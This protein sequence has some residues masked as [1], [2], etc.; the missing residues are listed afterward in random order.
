MVPLALSSL[1]HRAQ[2]SAAGSAAHQLLVTAWSLSGPE[3]AWPHVPNSDHLKMLGNSFSYVAIS[4]IDDC[5]H[6]QLS[7]FEA[8]LRLTPPNRQLLRPPRVLPNYR[9]RA[10]CRGC[11]LCRAPV[12]TTL[13][14]Y[15]LPRQRSLQFTRAL[16]VQHANTYYSSILPKDK[17]STA[18]IA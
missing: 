13:V 17:T 9:R 5:A 4:W 11:D 15:L 1:S 18:V 3:A 8:H 14:C 10:S 6:P 7:I 12:A 2:H 16:S